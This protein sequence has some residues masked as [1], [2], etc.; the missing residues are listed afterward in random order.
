MITNGHLFTYCTCEVG[1]ECEVVMGHSDPLLCLE[2]NRPI[3][4]IFRDSPGNKTW[5]SVTLTCVSIEPPL[6]P[7]ERDIKG[8]RV[9][10]VDVEC[11]KTVEEVEAIVEDLEARVEEVEARQDEEAALLAV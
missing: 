11:E 3:G 5:T 2:D 8:I 1:A 4:E 6:L 7:L 10:E 9:D